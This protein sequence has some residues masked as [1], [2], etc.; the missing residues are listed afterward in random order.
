MKY[1]FYA[2]VALKWVWLVNTFPSLV[3]SLS[4]V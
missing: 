3:V 2:S 4:G 1:V